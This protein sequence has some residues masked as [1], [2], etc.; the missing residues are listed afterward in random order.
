MI[1]FG[2]SGYRG[3]FGDDFTKEIVQKI[4]QA[5]ASRIKKEKSKKPVVIGYDRRFMSRHIAIWAAEVFAG[6]KIVCKL[7]NKSVPTPAVMYT[8]ME[9]D[10]DYGIMIT[11]SHNPYHHN[12]IKLVTKGGKDAG[13]DVTADIEK[14]ANKNIKIKSFN[15]EDGIKSQLI[16][17][18]DNINNYVK[19]IQKFM[20]PN[21]KNSDIKILF[22]AMHGVTG[23]SARI[24]A[25][26]YGLKNFTIVNEDEDPY[27]EHRLP[28]P[29]EEVL[30]DFIKDVKK[31]KYNIG[32]ACDGD[33]DRLGVIDEKGTYYDANT[34]LA[35]LYYYLIKYRNLSGD[36]VRTCATSHCLDL[37]ANKFN[38]NCH[39]V[40]V[41]FKW[42]GAKMKE[43]NAL[44]GGESS[45][46]LTMRNYIP[47]KDSMFAVCLI[48][49]AMATIKKPLSKIVKEVYDFCGYN[50]LFIE[51]GLKIN[52]KK[53]LMKSFLTSRPNFDKEPSE[54][55]H[56]SDGVKYVFEDNS[57]VTI[58]LSGT[59]DLLRY[60]MEFP[61]ETMC[62][63]AAKDILDYIKNVEK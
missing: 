5:L 49:D 26:N 62:D 19:K 6:N 43:T 20:S 58:R 21:L 48:L 61:N 56:L 46:G 30:E 41:G 53:K 12:G 11:A 13:L 27:F 32:L 4:C 1:K 3:T 2:T 45:G 57:F 40:P 31:G 28:C 14:N 37:L 39:E 42:V 50:S 10:L 38:F 18:F 16:V 44:L 25:K 22:N 52:K 47:S 35:T 8:V 7:Y 51:K 23:E 29:S 36:I 24:L 33:G 9:D 60:Y 59:E 15:Y 17:D 34:I 63:R 55:K 54:I